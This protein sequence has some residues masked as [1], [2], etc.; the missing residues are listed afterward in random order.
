[1]VKN[2]YPQTN[3]FNTTPPFWQGQ[4]HLFFLSL[5][6]LI[7]EEER[8]LMVRIL[9]R[10]HLRTIWSRYLL[11]D[12]RELRVKLAFT[13]CKEAWVFLFSFNFSCVIFWKPKLSPFFRSFLLFISC[14]FLDP[15]VK[16]TT[17]ILSYLFGLCHVCYSV[18]R[19][20]SVSFIC[21]FLSTSFFFCLLISWSMST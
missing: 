4:R 18:L 16:V 21:V 11:H 2:P 14:H 15:W 12:T 17:C 7:R 13:L 1:M 8:N 20:A 5:P 10:S 6:L 9:D 3:D 19:F